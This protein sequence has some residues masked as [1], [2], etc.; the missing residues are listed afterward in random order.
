MLNIVSKNKGT[1]R[2]IKK[3]KE[4]RERR[5]EGEKKDAP[6]LNSIMIIHSIIKPPSIQLKS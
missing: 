2:K 3:E 6:Q 5:G 4:K 1:N